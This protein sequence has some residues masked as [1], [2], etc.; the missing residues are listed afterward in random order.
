MAC[1][2]INGVVLCEVWLD[3]SGGHETWAL[4]T[5]KQQWTRSNPTGRILL[6]PPSAKPGK[7]ERGS[8]TRSS[9]ADWKALG[10]A[11]SISKMQTCCGSQSRAHVGVSRCTAQEL[12]EGLFIVSTPLGSYCRVRP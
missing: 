2:S 4:D 5:E 12:D 1:D 6:Q 10:L 3:E 11:G 7:A 8:V 9:F